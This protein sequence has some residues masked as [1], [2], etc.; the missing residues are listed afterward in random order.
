MKKRTA[1]VGSI[2]SII[3]FVQ[4][5]FL[6]TAVIFSTT[7]LMFV[8]PEKIKG[9]DAN[10]FYNRAIDK[11]EAGDMYGALSDYT[12]AIQIDPMDKQAYYNRGNLKREYLNDHA[13]AISDYTKAIQI[14]PKFE[15]AYFNRGLSKRLLND[16]Y[17]SIS[18]YNKALKLDPKDAESFLQRSIS[19]E[20]IGDIYGACSDAKKASSLGFRDPYHKRWIT[21]N[22]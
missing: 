14:D 10:F 19:K 1:L 3:P 8:V 11:Y 16:Y 9:E 13:G 21:D 18:D 12:K 17:G 22:C 20:I 6:K 7:G 15:N 2:L 5:S 4:I